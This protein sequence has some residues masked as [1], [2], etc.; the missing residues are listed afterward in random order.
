MSEEIEEKVCSFNKGSYLC[1]PFPK[2]GSVL[3]N[4]ADNFLT[5]NFL[6]QQK[7]FCDLNKGSYLCIPLEK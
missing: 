4:I 5:I 3:R 7:S 1:N 6:E 2:N